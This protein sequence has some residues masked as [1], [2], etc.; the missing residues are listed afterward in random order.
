MEYCRM[1]GSAKNLEKHH[2]KPLAEGGQDVPE[3][4]VFL[5]ESC[6]SRLGKRPYARPTGQGSVAT[7]Y[8]GAYKE[9]WEKFRTICIRE[10]TTASKKILEFVQ[11]YVTRHE[12]GNP[13]T[14]L[15]RSLDASRG[16]L[17]SRC[18]SPATRVYFT[19]GARF[20]TC[21]AHKV[22]VKS[23]PAIKGW[24]EL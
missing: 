14:R 8:I 2:L 11:E 5:C 16:P 9:S 13:Q 4:I 15:D 7:F 3:N 6:H 10:G 17:C 23:S 19:S 1:C 21:D 20:F 24:R 18:G 22:S 12:P